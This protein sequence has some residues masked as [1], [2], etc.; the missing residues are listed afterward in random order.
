MTTGMLK[1]GFA[2]YNPVCSGALASLTPALR[3]QHHKLRLHVVSLRLAFPPASPPCHRYIAL[4]HIAY[5]GL[6]GH[7]RESC[8]EAV[9]KRAF[10]AS[11]LMSRKYDLPTPA[12]CIL[13]LSAMAVKKTACH[14]YRRELASGKEPCFMS[15]A[16]G[17]YRSRD[18]IP[19]AITVGV[20]QPRSERL[21]RMK[22]ARKRAIQKA[23][24]T[25]K[26]YALDTAWWRGN[27]CVKSAKTTSCIQY[28]L[29]QQSR[30]NR[31]AGHAVA[32]VGGTST[33]RRLG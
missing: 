31:R 26:T 25:R 24:A 30:G 16:N 2:L 33:G 13:S 21:E 1:K 4:A 18:S 6:G 19:Y 3:S 23:C 27:Y 8:P 11:L 10:P 22:R 12:L 28:R 32:A 29:I 20:R 9:G 5:G 7:T 17:A 14:I 15:E